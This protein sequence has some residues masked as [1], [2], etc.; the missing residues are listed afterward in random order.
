MV[1]WSGKPANPEMFTFD[2]AVRQFARESQTISH[3]KVWSQQKCPTRTR[4]RGSG[5]SQKSCKQH[6]NRT[7]FGYPGTMWRSAINAKSG[8]RRSR[9]RRATSDTPCRKL[10]NR[11]GSRL[12]G[13]FRTGTSGTGCSNGTVGTGTGRNRNRR[14]RILGYTLGPKNSI[15]G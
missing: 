7:E 1:N 11:T 6:G 9:P 8:Q 3:N 14:N 13:R 2:Y 4:C 5:H 15:L 10:P 12:T